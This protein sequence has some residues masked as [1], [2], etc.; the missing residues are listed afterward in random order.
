MQPAQEGTRVDEIHDPLLHQWLCL[1][2]LTMIIHPT[3]GAF[4]ANSII[5]PLVFDS[6]Y[7]PGWNRVSYNDVLSELRRPPRYVNYDTAETLRTPPPDVSPEAIRTIQES[8]PDITDT[9]L[10]TVIEARAEALAQRNHGVYTPQRIKKIMQSIREAGPPG[11]IYNTDVMKER[12]LTA[13]RAMQQAMAATRQGQL[14]MGD[15]L[16]PAIDTVKA[17]LAFEL[18]G[19]I[20]GEVL[21]VILSA[22][23]QIPNL[24]PPSNTPP[25]ARVDAIEHLGN[26][27]YRLLRQRK[28]ANVTSYCELTYLASLYAGTANILAVHALEVGGLPPQIIKRVKGLDLN[29]E[30]MV[31]HHLFPT[32]I[33]PGFLSSRDILKLIM[34]ESAVLNTP[35]QERANFYCI[36]PGLQ[37]LLES[38]KEMNDETVVQAYQQFSDASQSIDIQQELTGDYSPIAQS[39]HERVLLRLVTL[40]LDHGHLS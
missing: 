40:T 17:Y 16:M 3:L 25:Q 2:R 27:A 37:Q 22:Q 36:H 6:S 28:T 5:N 9:R 13:L 19:I 38:F 26:I 21:A 34:D 15:F 14:N 18:P 29:L 1:C 4:Q 31:A 33:L 12:A 39:N 24:G 7:S 11:I 8:V 20:A 10:W 30:E 23:C 32:F 35:P